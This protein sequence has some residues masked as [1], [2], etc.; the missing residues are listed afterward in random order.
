MLALGS[1]MRYRIA[2]SL[3]PAGAR[4]FHTHHCRLPRGVRAPWHRRYGAEGP[5]TPCHLWRKPR[6]ALPVANPSAPRVRPCT[7]LR[8]RFYLPYDTSPVWM[9]ELTTGRR[10]IDDDR[11]DQR[12]AIPVVRGRDECSRGRIA[13]IIT[14]IRRMINAVAPHR[15]RSSLQR[16]EL[17]D[18][19]PV[20]QQSHP[21]AGK[22]R[23]HVAVECGPVARRMVIRNAVLRESLHNPL[24]RI[25]IAGAGAQTV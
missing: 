17:C 6:P 13:Q 7:N 20:I 14:H 8:T 1:A 11:A 3:D 25:A 23:Q 10:R 5:P 16:R 15:C 9:I 12:D 21:G 2:A 22:Q 4:G 19:P 18:E 24:G